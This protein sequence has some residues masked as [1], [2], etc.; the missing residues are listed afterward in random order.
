M[1]E[2]QVDKLYWVYFIV[3]SNV[4]IFC[5]IFENG[6]KFKST[7]HKVKVLYIEERVENKPKFL[8]ENTRKLIF[9]VT[10]SI[11]TTR[12]CTFLFVRRVQQPLVRPRLPHSAST[13]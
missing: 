7:P 11:E 1:Y 9:N 12:N 2:N 5:K 4:N 3:K 6:E 13:C 8:K 10:Q